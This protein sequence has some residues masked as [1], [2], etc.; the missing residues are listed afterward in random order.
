MATSVLLSDRLAVSRVVR[1]TRYL[2]GSRPECRG[3]S[4]EGS[5]RSG[6]GG[7]LCPLTE[8]HTSSLLFVRRSLWT[9]HNT[10]CG[11]AGFIADPNIGRIQWDTEVLFFTFTFVNKRAN[12]ALNSACNAG[13]FDCSTYL[14]LGWLK[15]PDMKMQDIKMTDQKWRQGAKLQENKQS[16]NRDNITIKRANF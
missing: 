8:D 11:G 9:T 2:V 14:Y 13:K 5:D 12:A 15:M 4:R 16:F 7:C 10:L 1:Q 6:S 3:E